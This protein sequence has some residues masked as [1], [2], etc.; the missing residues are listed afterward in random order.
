[1]AA[2]DATGS[3]QPII[4][5]MLSQPASFRSVETSSKAALLTR[6]FCTAAASVTADMHS[7]DPGT[8]GGG[9][10]GLPDGREDLAEGVA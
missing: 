7:D 3:C 6:I 2:C 1:M 10:G 5:M 9:R 4:A 8:G